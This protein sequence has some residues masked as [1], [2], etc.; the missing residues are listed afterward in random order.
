M[1]DH[2]DGIGAVG[3]RSA[4]HDFATGARNN[5]DR[6]CLSCARFS[7]YPEHN[8]SLGDVCRPHRKTIT[9][10][11]IE[12]GVV[13][14]CGDVFPENAAQTG[15]EAYSLGRHSIRP[16]LS[17]GRIPHDLLGSID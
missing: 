6:R 8:G 15:L 11:F 13:G 5:A 17:C 16:S 9:D 2:D 14:I 12:R 4:G 7:D 1:F 3:Q 10:S